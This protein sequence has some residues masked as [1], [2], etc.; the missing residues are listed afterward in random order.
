MRTKPSCGVALLVALVL[1]GCSRPDNPYARIQDAPLVRA[2]L[3]TA[4]IVTPN[5]AL[6]KELDAGGYLYTPLASNY[7]GAVSVQAQLWK[8]PEDFAHATVTLLA[9]RAGGPNLR[10]LTMPALPPPASV[11]EEIE[12]AFFRNVLG[13]EVPRLPEEVSLRNG[14]RVQ[15]WTYVVD[16]LLAAQQRLRQA[17]IPVTFAPVAITTTYLG[18]HRLMGIQAPDDTV[19]ELVQSATR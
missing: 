13:V 9:G 8:V 4:T 11:D 6:P 19:I 18:D 5:P 17:G 14:A 12:A 3:H 10:V 7:P 16:D 2:T 1:C 15:V